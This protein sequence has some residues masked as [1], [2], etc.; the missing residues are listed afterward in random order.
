M[1]DLPEEV[2]TISFTSFFFLD[3]L[4]TEQQP[5]QQVDQYSHMW[6]EHLV[7]R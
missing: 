1:E 3:L 2:D 5:G 4:G 7:A 6:I